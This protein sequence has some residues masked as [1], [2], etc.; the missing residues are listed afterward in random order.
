MGR[1]AERGA[2]FHRRNR[3]G[4]SRF[5]GGGR[6]ERAGQ[7]FTGLSGESGDLKCCGM[8]LVYDLIPFSQNLLEFL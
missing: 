7:R 8:E 1:E 5:L 4:A 6:R 3:E 2:G